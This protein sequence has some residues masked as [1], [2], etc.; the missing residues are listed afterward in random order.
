M[1]SLAV[2]TFPTCIGL[3]TQSNKNS[4]FLFIF[5]HKGRVWRLLDRNKHSFNV[6]LCPVLQVSLLLPWTR[7]ITHSRFHSP[8]TGVGKEKNSQGQ[9]ATWQF[10]ALWDL[11]HWGLIR[12][13]KGCDCFFD[14]P[15][16]FF[17]VFVGGHVEY[18]CPLFSRIIAF[19]ASQVRVQ[20]AC[21][22][23][24]VGHLLTPMWG[25]WNKLTKVSLFIFWVL[26]L[27]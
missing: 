19:S 26:F 14:R 2:L 3:L 17:V 25:F 16:V 6:C 5:L 18:W 9:Q 7:S 4:M 10:E 27:N 11:T 23:L 1:F 12:D 8:S 21:I 15:W 13:L 22:G 20:L 24:S